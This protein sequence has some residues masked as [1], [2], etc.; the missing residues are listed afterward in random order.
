MEPRKFRHSFIPTSLTSY[1]TGKTHSPRVYPKSL[2]GKS[3]STQHV[4][5]HG[6]QEA[7]MRR[8]SKTDV[9]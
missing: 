3:T 9:P 6:F 5:E 7:R 4:D 1:H 2:T 8:K